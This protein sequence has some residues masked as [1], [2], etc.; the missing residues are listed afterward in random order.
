[1]IVKD[2]R[3]VDAQSSADAPG[4]SLRWV[5]ARQDGAPRFAM[6]VI[7]VE[8]GCA[9]PHHS[10]W[11]E[12]EVFVLSGAGVVKGGGREQSITEG[13]V[14]FMPGEEM[15]QFVNTGDR[16]LRFICMVPHTDV[17]APS[18]IDK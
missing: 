8:P 18:C 15:H 9:T 4:V 16:P 1:M 7:E 14:V 3:N 6:R 12:H 2:Y 11:W 10:H 5:V 13:S 17:D